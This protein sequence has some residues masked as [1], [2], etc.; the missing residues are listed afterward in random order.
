MKK[1]EVG[2]N[3]FIFHSNLRKVRRFYP[4]YPEYLCCSAVK[5]VTNILQAKLACSADFN[6]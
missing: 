4:I 1:F 5:I 2:E 3:G 6:S